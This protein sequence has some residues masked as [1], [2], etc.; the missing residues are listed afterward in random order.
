MIAATHEP[1]RRPLPYSQSVVHS[2]EARGNLP[3][4]VDLDG[5]LV[6]SDALV[7]G[8]ISLA[9]SARFLLA[10]PRLLIAGPAILKQYVAS[11]TMVDPATLPYNLPFLEFLKQQKEKGRTLVLATAADQSVARAVADH[12]GIFDE[13]IA[14][15]GIDNLKGTA[16][17]AVL[18]ERFGPRGFVYA[19]NDASDLAV[20]RHAG[21]AI[22]VDVSASV[23]R[24]AGQIVPIEAT[25]HRAQG[26]LPALIKGMRPYQWVKNIL[27]WVP[28][29][30]AHALNEVAG[31]V[32][33]GLMFVAFC[34]T[35][36]AIYLINDAGDIHADRRHPR[37][38]FRPFA[39]G[40][41][42]LPIG[43][44][45]AA[46]MLLAGLAIGVAAGA[47]GVLVA[48]VVISLSYSFKLKEMPLVDIFVL[49]A[50]YLT[51]LIGGGQA[52]GHQVSLWLLGFSS[53]LF[54]G[55]GFLKRVGE[56]IATGRSDNA[57]LSRRGYMPGDA[58]ILQQFGSAAS[59]AACLMLA[60]FVQNEATAERY[61]SPTVLWAIVPLVLFWQCRLWLSTSRGYMHDDPIVYAA[62]DWVSWI[63]ALATAAVMVAAHS[64]WF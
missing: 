45:V 36:S 14:S 24:K 17:A 46:I 15:D 30:T 12:L 63:V 57:M 34:A 37:K 35:A 33:V 64:T 27:V 22:L 32:S 49:A 41:L 26:Y 42:P 40:A 10:L 62:R 38:R 58:V 5:T 43:L 52:A 47:T 16:K 53:F 7:E 54:L 3:L 4:C 48:Y 18:A 51:R 28:I 61:P 2:S 19:G 29:F 50:L 56:L 21:A 60:L 31:L 20:W 44:G 8:A 39:S 13:V 9:V 11:N 25:F 59:F 1:G 6:R 55:L 23:A